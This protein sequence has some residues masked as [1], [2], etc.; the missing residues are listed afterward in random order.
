MPGF[1]YVYRQDCCNVD[2]HK[3]SKVHSLPLKQLYSD[4]L[5]GAHNT[6]ER[7]QRLSG[8]DFGLHS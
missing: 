1:Q 6:I 7:H 8:E 2:E 4:Y 3:H 5:A